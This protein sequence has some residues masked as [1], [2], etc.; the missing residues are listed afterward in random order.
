MIEATLK[1]LVALNKKVDAMSKLF[2]DMY[3]HQQLQDQRIE[4]LSIAFRDNVQ[5]ETDILSRQK[6]QLSTLKQA[7][8]EVKY[9]ADRTDEF[10]VGLHSVLKDIVVELNHVH[11]KVCGVSPPPQERRGRMH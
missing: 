9:R 2:T 8:Q 10:L 11:E 4:R 5:A 7:T 3:S 1:E 6:H